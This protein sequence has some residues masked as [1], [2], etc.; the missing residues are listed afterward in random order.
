M[1]APYTLD[2]PAH[3]GSGSF[4][5]MPRRVEHVQCGKYTVLVGLTHHDGEYTGHLYGKING[6]TRTQTGIR[7]TLTSIDEND[8][9][10]CCTTVQKKLNTNKVTHLGELIRSAA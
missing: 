1:N 7:Y 9:A 5:M 6:S 10:A 2:F 4:L 3:V 8:I